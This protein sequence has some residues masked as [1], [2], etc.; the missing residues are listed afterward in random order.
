MKIID[1]AFGL[2]NRFPRTVNIAITITALVGIGLGVLLFIAMAEQ[3]GLFDAVFIYVMS[4]CYAA[5]IIIAIAAFNVARRRS[6]AQPSD[7]S[8]A[9]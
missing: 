8:D 6:S 4:A 7:T 1:R 2:L 3:R 9:D 5:A